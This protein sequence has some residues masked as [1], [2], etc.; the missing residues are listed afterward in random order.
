[1]Y[2][3][4][5]SVN[6]ASGVQCAFYHLL[7]ISVGYQQACTPQRRATDTDNF[8]AALSDDFANTDEWHQ[9]V[10]LQST[11]VSAQTL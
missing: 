1:M 8:E 2:A 7:L 10:L 3:A 11:H 5:H 9:N 6:G 4:I